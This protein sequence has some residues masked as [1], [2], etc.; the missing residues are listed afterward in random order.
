[1]WKANGIP[2][3]NPW[4]THG[5][6]HGK[7]RFEALSRLAARFNAIVVPFGGIGSA[8]NVRCQGRGVLGGFGA[9]LGYIYIYIYT[10]IHIYM[11]V[12]VISKMVALEWEIS[13]ETWMIAGSPVLGNLH[14]TNYLKCGAPKTT[15]EFTV[16]YIVI[17]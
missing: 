12:C 8:D 4:K 5:K 13:Q 1:M 6:R 9:R 11:C 17:L 2:I 7:P 14:K 10:Y 3:A 15:I 16:F